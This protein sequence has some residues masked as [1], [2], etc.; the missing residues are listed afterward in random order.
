LAIDALLV[1]V[2]FLALPDDHEVP[3]RI[4]RNRRLLLIV[5][6]GRV[7]EELDALGDAV[8]VE[9]LGIDAT[10]VAVLFLALPDDH[11]VPGRIHRN[12]RLLLIVGGGRVDEELAALGDAARIEALRVDALPVAVLVHAL[13]DDREVPRRIHRNRRLL[14]I[15]GGGGVDEELDALGYTVGVK[16]LC[17]DALPAAVLVHALPRDHEVPRRIHRN[18]RLLLIVGGGRVDEELDALGDAVGI[19]ALR[20]DTLP[21]AVLIHALPDD[22]EVRR[23]SC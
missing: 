3:G 20:V 10:P 1:A 7:D 2:L 6:G 12:R 9:A 15:G 13:P 17:V 16:A 22:H 14:L 4:H 5:S 8:G 18:H 19:E 23:W 21:V 11:E